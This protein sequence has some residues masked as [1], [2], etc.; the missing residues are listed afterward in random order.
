[1]KRRLTA[2]QRT[3]WSKYEVDIDLRGH[4]PSREGNPDAGHR[5]VDGLR[6]E[7][8]GL[9]THTSDYGYEGERSQGLSWMGWLVFVIA[10]T[11]G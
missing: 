2:T 9:M 5:E 4:C 3:D 7:G 8:C 6:N 11:E 1:M 10:G